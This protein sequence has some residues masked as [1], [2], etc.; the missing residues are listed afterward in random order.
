MAKMDFFALPRPVQPIET[1]TFVEP[2]FKDDRTKDVTLT[3]QTLDTVELARVQEVAEETFRK[4]EGD[5]E[6]HIEP[7]ASFYA[8]GDSVPTLNRTICLQ[9][10]F[11]FLMQ[12]PEEKEDKYSIEEFIAM[13]I[14]LP[15]VWKQI[16]QW[17]YTVSAIE[18]ADTEKEGEAKKAA[19]KKAA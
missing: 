6:N 14:V 8:V 10:A 7:E 17:R 19:P 11:L 16:S 4:Y 2:R 12:Q 13:S 9:A 15:S 18:E 5:P 1:K 3:L